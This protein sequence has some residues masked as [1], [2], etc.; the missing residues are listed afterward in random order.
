MTNIGTTRSSVAYLIEVLVSIARDIDLRTSEMNLAE[1]AAF[2]RAVMHL[3]NPTAPLPDFSGFHPAF[4]SQSEPPTPEGDVRKA[5]FLSY[6]HTMCEYL[7][8]DE[9]EEK[10]GIRRISGLG[11]LCDALS[12]GLSSAGARA[13]LQQG[14]PVLH[15]QPRHT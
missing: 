7:P 5:F 14:D 12:A 13:G 3:T 2:E 1:R 15:A 8:A 11:D 10:H 4:L 9:V 6:D